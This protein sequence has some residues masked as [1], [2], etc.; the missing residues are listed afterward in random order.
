MYTLWRFTLLACACLFL[1]GCTKTPTVDTRAEVEALRGIEE[2]IGAAIKAGE[3]DKLV[4]FYAAD[5]VLMDSD[6]PTTVG[7]QALH[8]SLETWFA[9]T[10][11][12]KTYSGTLDAVEVSVSADLA[13]TRGTSRF[14]YNTPKGLADYTGR[15][16]SVYKRMDGKWKIIVDINNSDRPLSGH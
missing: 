15:W 11:V 7:H 8:K 14:S 16:L 3:I 2:Q 12:T 1:A 4:G 13:F 9:D 5:A 10:M 6:V